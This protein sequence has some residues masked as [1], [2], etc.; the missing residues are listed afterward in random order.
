MGLTKYHGGDLVKRGTSSP[1]AQII[2]RA[3]DQRD[4]ANRAG[5]WNVL[6]RYK[7]DNV[8][9]AILM[10]TGRSEQDIADIDHA[11]TLHLPHRSRTS[12]QRAV[13]QGPF[14]DVSHKERLNL[15]QLAFCDEDITR[16]D[17]K[18]AEKMGYYPWMVFWHQKMM[19]IRQFV[20][21]VQRAGLLEISVVTF[22]NEN[23]GVKVFQTDSPG[24]V[25][26]DEMYDA[27]DEGRQAAEQ[28][29]EHSRT[30]SA[31]APNRN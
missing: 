22:S 12:S 29:L 28:Q 30:Q 25:V 17:P 26:V 3:K 11:A 20:I 10:Q 8:Y 16:I 23:H 21:A 31:N 24:D 13:G 5:F 7:T 9:A 6:Q 1:V 18:Y 4:N 2:R 27:F 15:A 14:S 19:F